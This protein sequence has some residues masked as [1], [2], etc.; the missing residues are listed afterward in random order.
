MEREPFRRAFVR[1]HDHEITKKAEVTKTTKHTKST[2]NT[3]TRKHEEDDGFNAEPA[4][5]A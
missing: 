3:K 5:P 4:K 1:K 2:K